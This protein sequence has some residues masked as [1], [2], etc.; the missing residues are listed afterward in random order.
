ML[1]TLPPLL[2]RRGQY[3]ASSILIGLAGLLGGCVDKYLPDVISTPQSYLVVDGSINLTGVTTV[4]L[5]RTRNLSDGATSPAETKAS[6]IIQDNAGS[7][8]PLTEQAGGVYTSASLAL[9]PSHQYQLR[10]RTTTGRE[11]ASDLV[12]AKASPAIDSLVW[13]VESKGIQIYASTHDVL[14]AARYYRWTYQ[15]TWEFYSAYQSSFEYVN[16]K[17]VPR[18]ENIN[19]CWHVENS[20][21]I[22]LSNNTALSQNVVVNFPLTLLPT[23]S[24]RLGVKYSILAQL[25][26]QTPEEFAYWEKLRKNTETL[27]TLFDPLPSQ[28]AGNVHC[29]S[30]ATELVLGYVGA[31]GVAEK[32]LFIDR[33]Q[34]PR[35][36]SNSPFLSPY[37]G[38][39]TMIV[40]VGNA[41]FYFGDY[42]LLPIFPADNYMPPHAYTAATPACVDC[43]LRGTNVKPSYWP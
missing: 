22:I 20:H 30:D 2:R 43:R 6:V 12:A 16:N 26:A 9:N 32:R 24:E 34:L 27:G 31:G 13:A 18:N 17:I 3:L 1:I 40:A 36:I 10:L 5:S 38:C 33:K 37:Q 7:Q 14:N 28:L 42:T 19:H 21:A 29:L 8:F 41:T 11:Y 23:N 35:S 15:E 39:D 25:H 4:Q